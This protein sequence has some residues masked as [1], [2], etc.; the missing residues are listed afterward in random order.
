M[1]RPADMDADVAVSLSVL[2]GLVV[3]SEATRRVLIRALAHSGL[4]VDAAELV[5]TFQLC[6]CAHELRLLSEVGGIHPRLALAFTYLV[7]VVHG[8]TFRGAIGNPCGALERA[9]HAT[10]PG[11]R[12]LRRIACQFAAA[13]VARAAALQVWSIGLSRLHARHRL[14]GFR[15]V[16]PVRGGSLHEAAAVELACA[17]AVQTVITHTQSVKEKYRVHAVAAITTAVVYAGGGVTG[18]VFN[19]AVAFSTHFHCSGNSF[20]EYCFVYWLGPFLG[21]MCSVLLFDR[22]S[23]GV[24]PP[25]KKK[26]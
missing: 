7:S 22:F 6:C 3:M 23:P 4:S 21:T 18:A 9:Y 11:G 15:C 17:F 1:R 25:Q 24:P 20:M 10:L 13:A 5:S 8:L 16:S 2:A 14:L 19:P 26:T 12:A